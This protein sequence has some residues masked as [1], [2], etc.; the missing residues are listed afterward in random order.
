MNMKEHILTAL[1]EQFNHWEELLVNMSEEQIN[2]PLLPSNWC[3]KNVITHLWA[4]QQISVA[5][6]EAARQD[7]E[8]EFPR[9]VAELQSDW[10]GNANQTNAWIYDT[11]REQAWSE[12]YQ[13]WREGFLQFLELGRAIPEKDLLDA[14]KVSV[15]ERTP[16][17]VHSPG[18]L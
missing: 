7:H 5:R 3:I 11:Y 1:K 18:F 17:H 13:N 9:W 15:A 4:W 12:A 8:P 6:M 14:G 2:A 10:E 16:S